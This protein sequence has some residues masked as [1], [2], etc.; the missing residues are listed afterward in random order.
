ME[1]SPLAGIE[2]TGT[3]KL[4]DDDLQSCLGQLGQE[5][6]CSAAAVSKRWCRLAKD[7]TVWRQLLCRSFPGLTAAVGMHER[8][9]IKKLRQPHQPQPTRPQDV[10]VILELRVEGNGGGPGGRW[11]CSS[12]GGP[13]PSCMLVRTFELASLKQTA[14]PVTYEHDTPQRVYQ[15]PVEK[16]EFEAVRRVAERCAGLGGH[17]RGHHTA[18]ITLLR[19]RDCKT[20]RV[21]A[22]PVRVQG[23]GPATLTWSGNLS[24]LNATRYSWARQAACSSDNDLGGFMGGQTVE[25]GLD[26]GTPSMCSIGGGGIHPD[27]LGESAHALFDPNALFLKISVTRCREFETSWSD[28]EDWV[29]GD[30][31]GEQMRLSV[32]PTETDTRMTELDRCLLSE[33]PWS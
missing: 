3:A 33:L 2:P 22:D 6:L 26:V 15:L 24:P 21:V 14:L 27:R 30:D 18:A 29:F 4:S 5:S 25:V 16:S 17:L 7:R 28:E 1:A 20:V 12:H 32:E 31:E 13:P 19:T 8:E 11:P 10:V 23:A 9:L